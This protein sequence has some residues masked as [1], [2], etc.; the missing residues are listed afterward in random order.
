MYLQKAL[1]WSSTIG[2]IMI[3]GNFFCLVITEKLGKKKVLL[4][5]LGG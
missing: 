5:G 1:F 2:F 4:I 3:L